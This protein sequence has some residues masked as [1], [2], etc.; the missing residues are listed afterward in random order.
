MSDRKGNAMDNEN[1]MEASLQAAFAALNDSRAQAEALVKTSTRH[2]KPW[3]DAKLIRAALER[4]I[5]EVEHAMSLQD[6]FYA[7]DDTPPQGMRFYRRPS[8]GQ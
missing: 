7:L 5:S 3:D 1:P 4:A 2:S 6:P 8:D